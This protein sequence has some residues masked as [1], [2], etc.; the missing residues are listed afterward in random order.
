MGD[1]VGKIRRKRLE[2]RT[3][4]NARKVAFSVSSPTGRFGV[5]KLLKIPFHGNFNMLGAS[6]APVA[7]T[8]HT[9]RTSAVFSSGEDGLLLICRRHLDVIDDVCIH[10]TRLLYQLEAELIL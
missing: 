1:R 4:L 9:P 6:T 8:S 7:P 3:S 2:L 5:G 10:G